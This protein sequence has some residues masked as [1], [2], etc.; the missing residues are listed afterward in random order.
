[1]CLLDLKYL[2]T[3]TSWSNC[4]EAHHNIHWEHVFTECPGLR[5]HWQRSSHFDPPFLMVV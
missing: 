1:M 5:L 3:A 2:H 4:G